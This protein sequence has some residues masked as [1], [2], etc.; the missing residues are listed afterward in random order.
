M[1]VSCE[2]LKLHS[3]LNKNY[4]TF[5]TIL[6]GKIARKSML[7]NK[8]GLSIVFVEIINGCQQRGP[9]NLERPQTFKFS[10]RIDF[11]RI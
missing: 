4:F 2:G 1:Y 8:M 7:L 6:K 5:K 9:S 10:P 3:V 11:L